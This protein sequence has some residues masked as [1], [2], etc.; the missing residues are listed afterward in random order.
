[1][2]P[3]EYESNVPWMW[4][5]S[6]NVEQ[7]NM[8]Q[9]TDSRQ[10]SLM[11]HWEV[12]TPTFLG[13]DNCLHARRDFSLRVERISLYS[14]KEGLLCLRDQLIGDVESVLLLADFVTQLLWWGCDVPLPFFHVS[15]GS[16]GAYKKTGLSFH[17]G[18]KNPQFKQSLI[19][20]LSKMSNGCAWIWTPFCIWRFK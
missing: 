6:S 10:D 16:T 5:I 15:P 1:M 18:E 20:S 3:S 19:L 9:D 2:R 4:N 13:Q 7:Q 14:P 8:P 17:W 12:Y 11:F